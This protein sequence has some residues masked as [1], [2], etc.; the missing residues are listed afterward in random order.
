ML[1]VDIG[2]NGEEIILCHYVDDIILMETQVCTRYRV[3][4]LWETQEAPVRVIGSD[5]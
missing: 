3:A 2:T 5:M 1:R 4:V